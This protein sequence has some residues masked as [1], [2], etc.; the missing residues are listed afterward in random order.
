[1][2]LAGG[3][4]YVYLIYGM[5]DCLNVVTRSSEEP[6]AVLIRAIEPLDFVSGSKLKKSEIPTNG[7]GK[8]CRFW[9]I[10][11]AQDGAALWTRKSPIWIEDG[12]RAEKIVAT[13]RIGVDYAGE[14]ADWPLRFYLSGNPFVS[15]R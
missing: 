5:Y 11:R 8:L 13:R 9:N 3:H 2:Y 14:A 4:A 10:S 1:M 7:P 15:K 12:E 6:E